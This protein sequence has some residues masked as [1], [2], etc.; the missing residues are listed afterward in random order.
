GWHVRDNF[1]RAPDGRAVILRGANVS[2][3]QKVAPYLDG[4][5]R[6]D[7]RRLYD[8]WGMN[9][10]RFVM[11]WAAV[12]PQK[13]QYDDAY[14]EGVRARLDWPS[15]AGLA[16]V[17]DMHEDVYGEGFGFDGAPRWTCDGA[18]YAAFK[19]RSPWFVNTLDP[20]VTACVD[21]FYT[22][23]DLQTHFAA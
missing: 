19:P 17:L 12:E 3:A 10:I 2:N 22:R 1:L 8:D 9:A 5:Q 15:A 14:L 18:R 4:K 23:A 20:S 21:D 7:Y 13:G 11:T 16:V 6:A